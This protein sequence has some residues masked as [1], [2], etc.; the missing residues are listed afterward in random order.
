MGKP[1]YTDNF[2]I[3]TI[4]VTDTFGGF[5][6]G[7]LSF[8]IARWLLPRIQARPGFEDRRLVMAIP[9]R[10]KNQ[11]RL[12]FN[13][14]YVVTMTLTT[15]PDPA[16]T[17]Q[18]LA[19]DTLNF[20]Q[21]SKYGYTPTIYRP[22]AWSSIVFEDGRERIFMAFDSNDTSDF[23][24][25][26][27]Y[28]YEMDVGSL[29]DYWRMPKWISFIIQIGTT[30]LT[31]VDRMFL[32]ARTQGYLEGK[33]T[34]AK[35]WGRPS[36]PD[37]YDVNTESDITFGRVDDLYKVDFQT[38]GGLVSRGF[39]GFSMVYR[40]E[41]DAPLPDLDWDSWTDAEWLSYAPSIDFVLQNGV[42]Y[43]TAQMD[44]RGSVK[45]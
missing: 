33:V 31:K 4:D 12:Y 14:G 8:K 44:S 29:F 28:V 22:S 43:G 42:L 18:R 40:F 6:T 21:Y 20:Y 15:D 23:Y 3:S 5:V 2:G 1:V 30:K 7:R 24:G 17:F 25:P 35:D 27:Q 9:V 26:R 34:Y 41:I 37:Y 38:E 16:F 36:D 45:A 32:H 13:D 10:N 11:Y 39:E 19:S